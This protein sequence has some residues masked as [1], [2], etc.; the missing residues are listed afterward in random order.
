M[1]TTKIRPYAAGPAT[2]NQIYTIVNEAYKQ[3]SGSGTQTAV[4]TASLVAMG[5][6]MEML[7]TYDIWLR[8]LSRMIGMTIDD[9]RVYTGQFNDMRRSNMEWGAFVRKLHTEMPE[10]VADDSV[11]LIDG[12]SIDQW[13]IANPKVKEKIFNV[14]APYSFFITIQ[15]R[16]LK[17]AFR[18]ESE[19]SGF[20]G[21]I[22]GAVQN[23]IE[24]THENLGRLAMCNFISNVGDDQHFKLVTMYNEFS[25]EALTTD[26][27]MND[28][29]FIAYAMGVIGEVSRAMRTMSVL[30]NK[31]GRARHTP[32]GLQRLAVLNSFMSGWE[33]I[34]Q[35]NVHNPEIG[36]I[37]PDIVVPYWQ[38]QAKIKGNFHENAK[39]ETN[40]ATVENVIAVLYDFDAMG[41]FRNN[42]EVHT[43]PVN[44]R[45][46]Y[47]N[48][49]WHENQM[50]FNDMGEN[51]VIFTLD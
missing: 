49:F 29:Y 22:F 23:K 14:E 4:D 18:N 35:R 47:Y 34:A 2:V 19:M 48:T 26:T 24:I 3:T 12:Q 44:A 5:Q 13:I 8:S 28:K 36:G 46:L 6:E 7:G 31:E 9:Y 45:G 50:Y 10:A 37:T 43:T 11:N 20:I 30:Y 17:E 15:H 33:T 16:W 25:G 21:S 42:Q 32:E 1:P 41:T 51:G 27:A 38:H 39:V 40:T